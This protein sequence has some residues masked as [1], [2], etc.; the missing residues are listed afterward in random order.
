MGAQEVVIS[1]SENQVIACAFDVVKAVCFPVGS[2]IGTVQPL[3]D[4]FERA[5]FFGNSIVVGKSNAL[6]DR[7]GEILSKLLCEFHGGKGDRCY[8]RQ[9]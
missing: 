2:L 4:L 5:V 3:H 9:Q 8:S 7:K 1:A 6:G